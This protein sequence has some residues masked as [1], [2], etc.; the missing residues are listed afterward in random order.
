[1]RTVSLI[2]ITP[3][4]GFALQH[5]DSVEVRAHGVL[6]NRRFFLCDG[7]GNR[8]RSSLSAWP[9]LVHGEY[10]AQGEVLGMRFPNGTEVKGSA[11]GNGE[12]ISVAHT[13]RTISGQIVHGAWEE[14]LA[15]LADHAVRIVRSDVPGARQHAPA[16][17]VSES[18]LVR[19]SREAV[20]EVDGR[21][22]RM[23]FTLADCEEHEED[24]WEG[25]LLQVGG[26][27]LRAGGPVERCAVTTRDPDTGIR[28]LD[29][30][31]L[32]ARYRGRGAGEPV[33]FGVYASVERPG[34]VRVGDR[35]E[36]L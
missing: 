23:L 30:L 9:C 20:S 15:A 7:E 12:R 28:D 27:V 1:V 36:P 8:L 33:H 16:T 17:L 11:L 19:L 3:V 26:A 25:R 24:R 10:D 21:R 32:I 22:F 14:P 35:V 4:Q 34:R 31:R 2:S 5:P 6:E 13:H 29:T 18:S